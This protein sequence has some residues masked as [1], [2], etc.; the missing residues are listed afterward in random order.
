MSKEELLN[1]LIKYDSKY[2]VKEIRKKLLKL[3]QEKIALNIEKIAKDQLIIT[4]LKSESNIAERNFEKLLNDNNDNTEDDTYDDKLTDKIHGI[5]MILNRLGNMV[6]AKDKK[7]IK[8][9]AK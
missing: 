7:E 4:L 1:T 6:T 5:R 3:G 8:K 2:E 9:K